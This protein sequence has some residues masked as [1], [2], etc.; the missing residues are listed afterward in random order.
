MKKLLALLLVFAS[1][2]AL[3]ACGG[4]QEAEVVENVDP[5]D[6]NMVIETPPA[7]VSGPD[8]PATQYTPD[9]ALP[10]TAP[11]SAPVI[12]PSTTPAPENAQTPD[13]NYQLNP[14]E[15]TTEPAP[16]PGSEI[17]F[18]DDTGDMY[19]P[20]ATQEEK[21]YAKTG[22]TTVEWANFRVGP[23]TNYK[24]YESLPKGTMVKILGYEGGWCKIWYND[25]VVGYVAGEF[26]SEKA[27]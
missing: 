21:L 10:T 11:T 12:V 24:I 6:N 26:I 5:G 22:Y 7:I 16:D 14:T 27:P 18:A 15:S 8:T 25:S 23:G 2:F 1:I 4:T 19:Y 13:P 9:T 20:T 3:A 17:E